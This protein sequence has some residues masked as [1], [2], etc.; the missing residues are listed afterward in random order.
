MSKPQSHS[1]GIQLK[2]RSQIC[3]L[4]PGEKGSEEEEWPSGPPLLQRSLLSVTPP[5]ASDFWDSK[6][7]EK[8]KEKK[9][10]GMMKAG[11]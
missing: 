2:R 1:L 11:P 3:A 10:P 5:V 6:G 8:K 9:E 7:K 4:G